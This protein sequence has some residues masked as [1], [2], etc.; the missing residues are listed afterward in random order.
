M[1]P[2]SHCGRIPQGYIV[3][4]LVFRRTTL[5]GV[6]K[7]RITAWALPALL[8]LAGPTWAQSS[9]SG[10]TEDKGS[11]KTVKKEDIKTWTMTVDGKEWSVRPAA[12][13]VDGDTGLFR[14]SSA[15]TLPRR[16]FSLSLTRDN[17]DRDPKGID[18][19]EHGLNVGFGATDRL[20]LFGHVGL[21]HRVKAHYLF[22]PGF[23]NEAP[24]VNSGWE[25]GFGDI[26]IGAKYKILD[27]YQHGDPVGLAIKGK[28]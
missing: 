18:Y 13:T 22:Q 16:A 27:D 15:Y 26:R 11:K 24:F 8:V 4:G 3:G 21:Q 1:R 10:T 6:M 25:T 28:V 14:L 20:E 12:P 19:S 7:G 9:A 17:Y 2:R 23:W 5:G